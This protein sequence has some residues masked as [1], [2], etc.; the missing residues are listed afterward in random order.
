LSAFSITDTCPQAEYAP[1]VQLTGWSF[2]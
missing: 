1:S 2:E